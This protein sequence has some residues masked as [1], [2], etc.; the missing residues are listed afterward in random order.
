MTFF[1]NDASV[2]TV[3]VKLLLLLLL[4]ADSAGPQHG[5]AY[6]HKRPRLR[7]HVYIERE[8]GQALQECVFF[9]QQKRKRETSLSLHEERRKV[10]HV[11]LNPPLQIYENYKNNKDA[12]AS[13]RPPPV[14]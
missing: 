3:Q 14:Q 9:F 10:C 4:N 12:N 8:S 1:Q 7:A 5:S 11:G 6:R 2:H 13:L